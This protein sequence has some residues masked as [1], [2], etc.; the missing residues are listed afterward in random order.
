MFL[1][2]QKILK[3]IKQGKI[4]ITPFQA[5]Y[6]GY[7]S[8]EMHLSSN[9]FQVQPK[10]EFF[11]GETPKEKYLK[12]IE[13][14][15]EGFVLSPK[16]FII[17]KT[18]EMIFCDENTMGIFDGK[19]SIAQIGLFTNISSIL[20]D[21]MTNS[22]ITCEIYN[23]SEYPIKLSIGQKIGQIFFSEVMN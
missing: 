2:N 7:I 4:K 20:V 10:S 9:L 3:F 18:Q 21:P 6:L 11:I 19:S 5:E 17:A 8:Y 14:N 12:P 22:E 13:I 16:R 1:S 15:D 23:A